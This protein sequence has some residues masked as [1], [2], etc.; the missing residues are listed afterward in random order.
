MAQLI[1]KDSAAYTGYADTLDHIH[2]AGVTPIDKCYWRA[3]QVIAL[4]Q[5]STG[6]LVTKRWCVLTNEVV[7]FEGQDHIQ[8]N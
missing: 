3:P 6:N 7:H 4:D 1:P 2:Q 5:K 8:F